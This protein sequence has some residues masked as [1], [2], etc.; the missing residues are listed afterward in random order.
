LGK[1]F[2]LHSPRAGGATFFASFGIS[3]MILQALGRWSSEAWRIYIRDNPTIRVEQQ[4][5]TL[6]SQQSTSH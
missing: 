2:G 6:R 5:A 4:L 1:E 3:E